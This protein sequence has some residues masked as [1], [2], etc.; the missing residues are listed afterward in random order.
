MKERSQHRDDRRQ[1]ASG[2]MDPSHVPPTGVGG[3]AGWG[4]RI[5]KPRFLVYQ[6]L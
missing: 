1:S 3:V 4:I 5:A 6:L 2:P